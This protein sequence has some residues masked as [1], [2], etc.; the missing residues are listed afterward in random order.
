MYGLCYGRNIKIGDP[1][2]T[3]RRGRV[4][5]PGDKLRKPSKKIIKH[6][7]KV[8]CDKRLI[9]RQLQGK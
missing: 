1:P 5:P 3:I 2:P 6:R 4:R 8:F 7:G 9:K